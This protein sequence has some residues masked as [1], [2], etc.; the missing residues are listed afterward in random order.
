MSQPRNVQAEIRGD[1]LIITV[2]VSAATVQN[3]PLSKSQKN[4]LVASTGSFISV[5]ESGFRI[6]LNVIK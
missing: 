5:G 6:G 4:K 3:S 2:D 1:K